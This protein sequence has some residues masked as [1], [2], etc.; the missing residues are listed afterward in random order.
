MR[1]FLDTTYLMPVCG[2]NIREIQNTHLTRLFEQRST[3]INQVSLLELW[4]KGK[5]LLRGDPE[6][7]PRFLIGYRSILESQKIQKKAIIEPET[8]PWV[9][10]LSMEGLK[11]LLDCFITASAIYHSDVFVTE[12]QDI[13]K[14]VEI[15]KEK[16]EPEVNLQALPLRDF[17]QQYA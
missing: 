17:L 14:I 5:R 9:D 8:L 7:W 10:R 6:S 1:I 3:M 16:G 4:G 12:A 15:L 2:L 13:T 11:D